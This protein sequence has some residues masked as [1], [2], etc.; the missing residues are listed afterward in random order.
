[1]TASNVWDWIDNFKY[2]ILTLQNQKAADEKINIFQQI[3]F[4]RLSYNSNDVSIRYNK[5]DTLPYDELGIV[6]SDQIAILHRASSEKH[7]TLYSRVNSTLRRWHAFW[8]N[9]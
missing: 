4:L 3:L 6:S 8:D 7:L 5:S 1:M 9:S 2:Q